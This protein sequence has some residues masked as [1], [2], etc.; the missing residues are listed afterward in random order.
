MFFLEYCIESGFIS[1]DDANE[2][3]NSFGDQVIKLVQTQ[4]ARYNAGRG[5]S[6]D[7]DYLKLIR[8]FY[9]GKRF[10]LADSEKT[11]D[12]DKHDGLVYKKYKC[13]CLRRESLEKMLLKVLPNVSMKN[14]IDFLMEKSVKARQRQKHS[15]DINVE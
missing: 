7:V 4:Q 13:L 9:K 14:V 11:F 6:S 3:Y 15:K 5:I 8:R 10:S 1:Q 2:A 12:P